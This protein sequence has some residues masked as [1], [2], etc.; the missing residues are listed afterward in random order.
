MKK[1]KKTGRKEDGNRQQTGKLRREKQGERGKGK[2]M[3]EWKVFFMGKG[4]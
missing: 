3:D 2:I 4:I 1:N